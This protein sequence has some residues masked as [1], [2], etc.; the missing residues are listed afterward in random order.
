[1]N[2]IKA[3]IDG[4]P[5]N[6]V[7]VKTQKDISKGMSI[8]QNKEQIGLN[9]GMLFILAG[10]YSTFTMKDVKFPL[11]VFIYNKNWKLISSWISYPSDSQ[12]SFP[13]SSIDGK[14][15]CP[16]YMIEI[17]LNPSIS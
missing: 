12:M 1:M 16:F 6:L 7:V 17:P 13:K 3:I 8:Y 15:E 9:K 14:Y 5:Y 4:L 2:T 10:N 11:H